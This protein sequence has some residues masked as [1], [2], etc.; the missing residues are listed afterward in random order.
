MTTHSLEQAYVPDLIPEEDRHY[1]EKGNMGLRIEWGENPCVLV[2]DMTDEFTQDEYAAGRSDTGSAA[3]EATGRLLDTAR[4][5]D[6][7]VVFTQPKRDLPEKYTGTTKSFIGRTEGRPEKPNSIASVLD[8]RDEE[9]VINKPRASAFF[10]TYLANL[11]HVHGIDTLVV[12]GMTTS[13]CVRAT[14]VDAHSSNFRTIV[15]E[16]CVADRSTVSHEV[17]LFDIDMKYANVS[18]LDNVVEHLETY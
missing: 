6:I 1:Y 7:P 14:V 18:S 5:E 2:V 11:L 17:N 16:E 3:L 10:D 9:H 4:S 15:P 8:P 12:A 13:G